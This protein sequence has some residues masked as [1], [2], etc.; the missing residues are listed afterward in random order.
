MNG[1]SVLCKDSG[2]QEATIGGMARKNLGIIVPFCSGGY[3]ALRCHLCLGVSNRTIFIIL[4][5]A[6]SVTAQ[7][8]AHHNAIVNSIPV[9]GQL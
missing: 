6:P 1:W 7:I 4:S 2:F 8:V 9:F 5:P 3:S